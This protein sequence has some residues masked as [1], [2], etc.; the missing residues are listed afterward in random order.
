LIFLPRVAVDLLEM[1][2]NPANEK[3]SFYLGNA[4]CENDCRTKLTQRSIAS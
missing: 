2:G 3:A 1:S 4:P